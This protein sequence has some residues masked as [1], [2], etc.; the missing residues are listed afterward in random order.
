MYKNIENLLKQNIYCTQEREVCN[1]RSLPHINWSSFYKSNKIYHYAKYFSSIEDLIKQTNSYL[2]YLAIKDMKK[3]GNRYKFKITFNVSLCTEKRKHNLGLSEIINSFLFTYNDY[4]HWFL[5]RYSSNVK[6]D[7]IKG[8]FEIH[9]ST[10]QVYNLIVLDS[11]ESETEENTIELI[12]PF[13]YDKCVVCLENKPN[14]LFEKCY[15]CCVCIECEK[16]KPFSS[17]PCCRKKNS[18]KI[19]I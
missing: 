18:L 1:L 11:A 7:K 9:I 16:I 15:H 3:E 4:L 14:I 10:K 19:N 12:K 2:Y 13:L 5:R 6:L 17:C 8:P